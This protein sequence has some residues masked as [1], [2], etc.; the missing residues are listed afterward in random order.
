MNSHREVPECEGFHWL[1]PL[2][3]NPLNKY[4]LS[5]CNPKLTLPNPFDIIFLS[6]VSH[7]Q[8]WDDLSDSVKSVTP[9]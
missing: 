9:S 7:E 2:W 5:F 4:G 8:V 6:K 1:A 3:I